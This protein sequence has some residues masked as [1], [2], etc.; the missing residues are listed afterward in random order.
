[1][2]G[3]DAE[4]AVDAAEDPAGAGWG[5]NFGGCAGGTGKRAARKRGSRTA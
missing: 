2:R 4:A 1:M 3:A 5:E